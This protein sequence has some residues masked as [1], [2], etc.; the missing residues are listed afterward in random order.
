VAAA[1]ITGAVVLGTCSGLDALAAELGIRIIGPN[2]FGIAVPGIGLNVSLSHIQPPAGRMALVTQSSSL[3]RAVL[4]WAG[5]NGVGFSHIV[6]LGG[7]AD[8]GFSA[9]LDWLSRDPST[10]LILFDIRRIRRPRMV[11]SA[12]RAASRLRPVVAL[13]PGSRLLDPTGEG[14]AVF[15]AAL[16]RAGVFM[17]VSFEEFL[18]AAETLTR[19]RPPRADAVAIVTNAIGPG[20]LAA[21]RTRIGWAI[22]MV[23]GCRGVNDYLDGRFDE[24]V[25]AAEQVLK[26]A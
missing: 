3:A 12:A 9:V 6:G 21:E 1:R 2:S 11:L 15:A 20:R 16:R 13:R 26:G 10:G 19:S 4:D 25:H 14:E 17:V 23:R 22:D 5:P 24:A 8:F 7:N 18:A